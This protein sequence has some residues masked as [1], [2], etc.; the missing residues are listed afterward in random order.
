MADEKKTE[1]VEQ[2]ETAEQTEQDEG[3]ALPVK[4]A[5]MTPSKAF[6]GFAIATVEPE[7]MEA[8]RENV[9]GDGIGQFDLNRIRIPAGGGIAWELPGED[10][11]PEVVKDFVGLILF[12]QSQ[13]AYWQRSFDETGGGT[14]PD[15]ASADGG[16][17]IGL[18]GGDC[19]VC[20]F[21]KFGSAPPRPDGTESRGQ[22]CR[23]V[24]LVFVLRNVGLLP[25]VIPLPPT[26]LK[27][28]KKYMVSLGSRGV[29][30]Y[31]CLTR[32]SLVTDKS[33][34]GIRYS[35]AAF[36][37]VERLGIKQL[38]MVKRLREEWMPAFRQTRLSVADFG[39]P[40]G[41]DGGDIE[42]M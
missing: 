35:K 4:R 40:D 42:Q 31:G 18:P 6:G 23:Q 17:G 10:G 41:G 8:L 37:V 28:Y 9:A 38:Q 11:E 12:A 27:G 32:F 3:A 25:D 2:T 30:F 39:E 14:P 1:T 26:S 5:D 16:A 13:R 34:T 19:G 15:C 20:R 36:V 24:K 7:M 29:P 33:G 21:A 22:A